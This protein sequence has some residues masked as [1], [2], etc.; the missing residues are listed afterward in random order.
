MRFFQFLTISILWGFDLILQGSSPWNVLRPSTP[1]CHNALKHPAR[2]E[3][4]PHTGSIVVA[5]DRRIKGINSLPR[6]LR[7]MSIYSSEIHRYFWNGYIIWSEDKILRGC[8]VIAK[9]TSLNIWAFMKDN[10]PPLRSCFHAVLMSMI[11][12]PPRYCNILFDGRRLEKKHFVENGVLYY[13]IN[14]WNCWT[15]N[16]LRQ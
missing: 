1:I 6:K 11:G 9:S 2:M 13:F 8:A 3:L 16:I 5:Q 12:K 10:F 7:R 4:L 14:D 15:D